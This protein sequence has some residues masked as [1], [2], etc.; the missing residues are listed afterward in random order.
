MAGQLRNVEYWTHH[1]QTLPKLVRVCHTPFFTVSSSMSNYIAE[2]PKVRFKDQLKYSI[3]Q[4]GIS[5]IARKQKPSAV[6]PREE[7]FTSI[8][9]LR[10]GEILKSKGKRRQRK[11]RKL[12]PRPSPGQPCDHCPGLFHSLLGLSSHVGF[13]HREGTECTN[14]GHEWC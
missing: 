5:L 11:S 14:P 8:L 7:Q 4:A 13:K 3:L 6:H 1:P 9:F 10:R 2:P 12:Q